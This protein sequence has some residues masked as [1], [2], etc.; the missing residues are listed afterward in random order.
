MSVADCLIDTSALPRILL[1]Q[2]TNEWE[3]RVGTGFGVPS[4]RRNWVSAVLSSPV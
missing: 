4:L 3:E 2:A 1:H